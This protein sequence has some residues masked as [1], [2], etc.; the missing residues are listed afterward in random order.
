MISSSTTSQEV[1]ISRL[2]SKDI[3]W[4]LIFKGHPQILKGT[5]NK[6]KQI[7]LPMKL[8]QRI[9]EYRK[10]GEIINGTAGGRRKVM[11]K[12]LRV[13]ECVWRV[14]TRSKMCYGTKERLRNLKNKGPLLFTSTLHGQSAPFVLLLVENWMFI[15]WINQTTTCELGAQKTDSSRGSHTK[16]TV[17]W[18]ASSWMGGTHLAS[19]LIYF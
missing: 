14:I 2:P 10:G 15:L 3:F 1:F 5:K 16:N 4:P 6:T 13:C 17:K 11:R 19:F 18:V 9:S 8:I 12:W 7:V